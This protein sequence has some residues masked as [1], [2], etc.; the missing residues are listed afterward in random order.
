MLTLALSRRLDV[1]PLNDAI[2]SPALRLT[3]GDIRER[4]G[5]VD[6]GMRGGVRGQSG[7]EQ[8]L[9]ARLDGAGGSLG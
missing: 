5:P 3:V 1:E 9:A 8:A 4:L 7:D 2:P 6:S